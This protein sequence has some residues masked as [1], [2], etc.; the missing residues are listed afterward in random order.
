MP[1]VQRFYILLILLFSNALL[2]SQENDSLKPHKW[3]FA[4]TGEYGGI[5]PTNESLNFYRHKAFSGYN[6]QF[7][8]Q[9][10]GS[11][12]W[13]KLYNYPQIGFGVFALDFLKG[14]DMGSP[15][16][17][18]GIYNARINQWNRLKWM[19]GINFGIS[20]NS[21][22]FDFD[23]QYYNISIG[24]K[25]NMYIGLSTGLHY[26]LD[27]HF[28]VGLNLKFNHLSNGATKI[29]NK[30]L[31]MAAGQLSLIYY[32]ERIK[33]IETDTVYKPAE[34]HNTL[35][36][37]VFGGRK[38]SFYQGENRFDLKYYEGYEY[39]V[40]GADA[41]YMH[42]YSDKSAYGLGVGITY[43]G[44]Y[45]HTSYVQD[46]TLYEKKRFSNDRMLLSIIPTYRLMIGKLYVNIGAGVYPFKKTR[47]YDKDI[48]FQKIG[49]QYQ[50]TDRLFASFGI[51]A[52]NFHIANYLEWKLGY[53]IS[54]KKNRK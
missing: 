29:P 18:Y 45:N 50:I 4:A 27:E 7:L 39:N 52:Y 40:F 31:N 9:T 43:D 26:E 2:F 37:S 10:D 53:T 12:E 41:L 13:E 46:S 25:T 36:F 34:R 42:Q 35:E 14:K 11:R 19:Y 49:L 33:P 24:S 23:N 30:G 3:A 16:G 22:Y 54:K 47:Q 20:F 8:K 15:Y 1:V 21:N 6:V 38:D 17:F 48:F 44:E 32:P 5:I 51:N 28:D